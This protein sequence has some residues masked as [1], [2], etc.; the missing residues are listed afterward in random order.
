MQKMLAVA[1]GTPVSTKVSLSAPTTMLSPASTRLAGGN[2][3]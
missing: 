2:Y 3:N 1:I